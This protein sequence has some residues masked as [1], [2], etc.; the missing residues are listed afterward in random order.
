MDNRFFDD[1]ADG[2]DALSW[3]S[4]QPW[5]NGNIAMYGSSYWGATQWLVAPEQHP[6]LKAK[7]A[8]EHQS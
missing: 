2:Y 1:A 6:N 5:C 3:I 4:R 7:C 8:P